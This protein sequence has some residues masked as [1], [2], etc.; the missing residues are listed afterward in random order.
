MAES[1]FYARLGIFDMYDSAY[2]VTTNAEPPTSEPA[3]RTR[4]G[5]TSTKLEPETRISKTDS[6]SH[7]DGAHEPTAKR[8]WTTQRIPRQSS[9]NAVHWPDGRNKATHEAERH[10]LG[11]ELHWQEPP[12]RTGASE[13]KT[14]PSE[15]K[16]LASK[17]CGY[18]GVLALGLILTSSSFMLGY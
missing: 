15:S 10:R 2:T 6:E 5:E 3:T 7:R 9:A 18:F 4:P 1:S 8:H 13:S 14:E 17:C 11:Q 12:T 16:V